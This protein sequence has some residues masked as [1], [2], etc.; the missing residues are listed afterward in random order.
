MI[1]SVS[2]LIWAPGWVARFF[3]PLLMSLS[4]IA[5]SATVLTLNRHLQRE[6]SLTHEFRSFW[7][8]GLRIATFH[9]AIPSRSKKQVLPWCYGKFPELFTQELIAPTRTGSNIAF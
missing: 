8:T 2:P 9:L 5:E 3:D 1:E 4:C 6:P 7:F